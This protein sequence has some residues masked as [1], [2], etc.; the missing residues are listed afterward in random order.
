MADYLEAIKK[1]FEKAGKVYK[2]NCDDYKFSKSCLKF[3]TYNLL[4]RGIPKPDYKTAYDYY[5]K[6]CSGSDDPECCLNQGLLLVTDNKQM[7]I[8]QDIS[9]VRATINQ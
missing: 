9:K 7:G 4:G 2:H 6:G 5:S 1:D 3:G 8:E